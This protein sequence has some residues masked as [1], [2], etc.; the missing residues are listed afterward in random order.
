MI[1]GKKEEEKMQM[2]T[3]DSSE[4]YRHYARETKSFC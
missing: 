1:G 4:Q 3:Y 2:K